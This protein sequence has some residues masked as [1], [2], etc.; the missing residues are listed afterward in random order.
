MDQKQGQLSDIEKQKWKNRNSQKNATT[1][2]VQRVCS[3][4]HRHWAL[5]QSQDW[6]II[7]PLSTPSLRGFWLVDVRTVI[8][9]TTA[10]IFRTHS[11]KAPTQQSNNDLEAN[12]VREFPCFGSHRDRCVTVIYSHVAL[13]S[14]SSSS[15]KNNFSLWTKINTFI[16]I[17]RV[18]GRGA[19]GHRCVWVIGF[20]DHR[21]LCF[22]C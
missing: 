13:T 19:T 22:L 8:H 10:D 3:P 15:A 1:A 6:L 21:F 20:K 2:T 7:K 14:R 18:I 16:H 4:Q 5:Q 12:F 9:F 11:I 17:V